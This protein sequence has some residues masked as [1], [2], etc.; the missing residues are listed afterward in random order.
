[1]PDASSRML[2]GFKE[3]EA[4]K[5]RDANL[6]SLH[7][8]RTITRFGFGMQP[9]A[10]LAENLWSG[11]PVMFSVLHSLQTD[12]ISLPDRGIKQFECGISLMNL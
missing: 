2:R 11:I 4:V 7:Q 6:I 9:Q 12:I 8:H 1:M 5:L 3:N 10:N